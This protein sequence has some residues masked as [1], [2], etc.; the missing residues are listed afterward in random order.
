MPVVDQRL[1]PTPQT[2]HLLQPLLGIPH[3]QVLRVQPHF[4]HFTN[5]SARHRIRVPLDVQRAAAVHPTLHLPERLQPPL[6]Q[7]PQDRQLLGQPRAPAGIELTEQL[8]QEGAVL[9]TA[10]EVPTAPQQQRLLHGLLEAMVPLLDVA[11]LVGVVR[12]DLLG[13]QPIMIH[14]ALVTLRE[15]LLLGQVVDRRAQPVGSMPLGHAAQFPQRILQAL[16]Q[17]LEALREADRRRLPVR[18]AQ[19]EVVDQVVERLTLD[20]HA[21]AAHAREVRGR[22]PARF[23]H[24]GE[25]HLLRWP[26]QRS[27]APHLPLQA[28]QLPV[29]ELARMAPLQLA[30]DRLGLQARLIHQHRL[31]L[32]PNTDERIDARPPVVR[33]RRCA[34][35]LPQ[36]PILPRRLLVHVRPRCRRRQRLAAGQQPQQLPYLPVRDHR[37]PPSLKNLRTVYR[38]AAA[39]ILI[40]VAGKSNC[41]R[42]EI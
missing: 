16:T 25:E 18:V 40:V 23:V 3:L 20:A 31:H 41:R 32:L 29:R 22:Q 38:P 2:R 9:V 6:R 27:P 30:E 24:L 13:D 1:V 35:Q 39:G 36:P 42:W 26:G 8:P 5:Q 37:K 21:Q 12:L 11:V 14:Q 33:P 10:G 19:H 34:R 7:G 28:P 15:V 17:A 4:D